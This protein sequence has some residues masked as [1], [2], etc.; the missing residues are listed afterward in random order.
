[1][2]II[3][4]NNNDNDDY[5]NSLVVF[6][7]WFGLLMLCLLFWKCILYLWKGN[8]IFWVVR[9][10]I[11]KL[12]GFVFVLFYKFVD[13]FGFILNFD[14]LRGVVRMKEECFY[15]FSNGYLVLVDVWERFSELGYVNGLKIFWYRV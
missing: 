13:F 4:R 14:M 3:F 1:M 8:N 9:V 2:K 11:F 15:E 7:V 12:E 6:I 5:Y 10:L